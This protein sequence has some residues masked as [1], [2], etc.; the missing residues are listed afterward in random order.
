MEWFALYGTTRSLYPRP[1]WARFGSGEDFV[2]N[3]QPVDR[4]ADKDRFRLLFT[5]SRPQMPLDSARE[6]RIIS[7]RQLIREQRETAEA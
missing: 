6:V 3:N 2:M 1:S 7:S 5:N 4:S